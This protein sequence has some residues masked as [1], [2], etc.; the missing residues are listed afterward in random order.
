MSDQPSLP[1]LT[2]KELAAWRLAQYDRQGGKCRLCKLPLAK[3]SMVADHDH[4]TGR[5]RGLLHRACNS[6]LGAIE[7]AAK[8]YGMPPHM[9]PAFCA[10]VGPYLRGAQKPLI[11]P[12]HRTPEEK[13]ALRAKRARAARRVLNKTRK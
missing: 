9:F 7:N 1:R 8:R 11:Y 6:C 4:K 12:T 2:V 3:A 13:V 10:G 5:I